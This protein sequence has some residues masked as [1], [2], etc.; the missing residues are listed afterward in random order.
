MSRVLPVDPDLETEGE[1][2][3]T[4]HIKNWTKLPRREHGPKFECAGAPW[5]IPL[6]RREQSRQQAEI[7]SLTG[8]LGEYCFSPTVTR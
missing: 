7:I 3:H 8:V 2:Y 5:Y 6:T 1:T 4:W